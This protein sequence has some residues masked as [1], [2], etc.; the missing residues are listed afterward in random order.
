VYFIK[1]VID[2]EVKNMRDLY[3]IASLKKIGI[4][5]CMGSKIVWV[6]VLATI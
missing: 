5:K 6:I 4:V 3:I 2:Y 1:N